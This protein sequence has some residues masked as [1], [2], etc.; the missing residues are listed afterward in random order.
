MG[1][2]NKF[3]IDQQTL[4]DIHIAASIDGSVFGIFD[5]TVTEGGQ[6]IL[7]NLFYSPLG[8]VDLIEQ[9]HAKIKRLIPFININFSFDRLG[10]K[11]LQLYISN[12]HTEGVIVF[13]FL[14]LFRLNTPEYFYKKRH[15]IEVCEVLIKTRAFVMQCLAQTEDLVM[16]TIRDKIEKCLQ[17]FFKSQ[18][19]KISMLK[20]N[21]FN[22]DYYDRM[23]RKYLAEDLIDIFNFIYEVDAYLS[24][25]KVA[26]HQSFCFPSVYSKGQSGSIE[27]KGLYH[28]F[29]KSPVKNDVLMTKSKKIWFLTGANMAGKSTIIK[30]ISIAVYLTH[31]G[32]PVPAYSLKTD[33]LDGLFTSVNLFDDIEL[34]YSHFYSEAIRLK[35][36]LDQLDKK[37]NALIILDE[38]FKGTNHNDASQAILEV[39]KYLSEIDGPSVIIS[40]HITDL[41]QDLKSMPSIE[42]IKLD[43]EKDVN[44]LP[45][46]TYKVTK[47]VAE[48]R[49][50]M[51]LLNKSGVF[52]SCKRLIS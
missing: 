20:V 19:Y 50:G 11:D 34:G 33:V 26:V 18:L 39:I 28:I 2:V 1:M 17:N 32:F 42:F 52:D 12:H 23:I 7:R 44:G 31:I 10:L 40:S 29:H 36:I 4:K 6:Q 30:T 16:L 51:W 37:S 9:R 25:A 24:I 21:T 3:H 45:I 27:I 14:N 43:I 47:G 35:T 8:E 49:L 13:N 38:L 41:Y 48:E 5:Q 15:I 46:F 22:I